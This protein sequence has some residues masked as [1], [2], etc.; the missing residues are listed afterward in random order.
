MGSVY[1]FLQVPW[2]YVGSVSIPGDGCPL[3][4]NTISLFQVL[5]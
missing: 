5:Q 2:V 1:R 4:Y 3:V